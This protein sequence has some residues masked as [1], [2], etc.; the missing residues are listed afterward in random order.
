MSKE[1]YFAGV[2]RVAGVLKFRTAASPARFQQLGK[3][4]DTDVEMVNVN[5]DSK[6]AAAK[7]LLSR[8]FA[9]GRADIEALLVSVAQDDN[10]FAKP[11]K[12][13]GTVKVKRT[14]SDPV[15]AYFLAVEADDV[16]L[17]PKQAAKIRAEFNE[18]VRIA[19]EAN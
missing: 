5:V 14:K 7:E 15:E 18:R 3:L 8:N 2:S 16:K 6:S 1:I 17:T 11:K 12:K 9:N 10:P 19:Y 4:G 13:S